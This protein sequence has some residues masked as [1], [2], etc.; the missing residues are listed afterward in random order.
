M[1]VNMDDIISD[2]LKHICSKER[3]IAERDMEIR[4]LRATIALYEK[5]LNDA[6]QD[7]AE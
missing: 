7:Y 1:D 6:I 2:L 4:S 3:E 5:T